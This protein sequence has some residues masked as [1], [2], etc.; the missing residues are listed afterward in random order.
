[1]K[2]STEELCYGPRV[3][4]LYQCWSSWERCCRYSTRNHLHVVSVFNL[5]FGP[6]L[7]FGGT[8]AHCQTVLASFYG[9]YR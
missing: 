7:G 1:M 3:V 5:G 9:S 2:E 6:M 8:T 4:T